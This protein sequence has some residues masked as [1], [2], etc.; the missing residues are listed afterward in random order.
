MCRYAH[1][2]I[3]DKYV[4]MSDVSPLCIRM[5]AA[6]RKA[7][8]RR[9]QRRGRFSIRKALPPRTN[10]NFVEMPLLRRFPVCGNGGWVYTAFTV[11]RIF[12]A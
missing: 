4:P 12:R 2:K 8:R 7:K 10:S 6:S 11:F 5:L 3:R 9:E 1:L